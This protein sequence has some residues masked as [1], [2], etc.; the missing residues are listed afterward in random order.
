M[1]T[2][3]QMAQEASMSQYL[4]IREFPDLLQAYT[5]LIME[6]CAKVCEKTELAFDIDLWCDSTK[7]EMTAH[8]ARG[9]AEAIRSRKF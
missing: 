7:K 1:K 8:T 3:D 9:L 4:I 6:E 5:N 2:I